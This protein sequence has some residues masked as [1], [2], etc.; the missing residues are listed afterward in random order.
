MVQVVVGGRLMLG[1]LE[2]LASVSPDDSDPVHFGAMMLYELLEG[3]T[4]RD[5]WKSTGKTALCEL[6]H[7]QGAVA[8]AQLGGH[9]ASIKLSR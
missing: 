9:I 8:W 6:Q 1:K 2:W 7:M 3:G 4:R 5:K